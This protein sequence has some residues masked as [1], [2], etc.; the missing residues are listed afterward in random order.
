[1]RTVRY[2]AVVGVECR[3]AHVP[4]RRA[5]VPE[6]D[7]RSDRTGVAARR[8]ARHAAAHARGRVRAGGQTA[9]GAGATRQQGDARDVDR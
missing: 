4:S 5:A 7:E 3:G 2:S 8:P 6:E 1:M 9:R